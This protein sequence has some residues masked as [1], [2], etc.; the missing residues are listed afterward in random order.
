MTQTSPWRNLRVALFG[1]LFL[2]G[3]VKVSSVCAIWFSIF[4]FDF[5]LPSF[6]CLPGTHPCQKSLWQAKNFALK[7]KS[8]LFIP[9]TFSYF[10]AFFLPQINVLI[11]CVYIFFLA[12]IFFIFAYVNFC[13]WAKS[14]LLAKS[15]YQAETCQS[16]CIILAFVLGWDLIRISCV[17]GQVC[18]LSFDCRLSEVCTRVSLNLTKKS[19]D[20]H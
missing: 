16:F 12:L 6:G 7:N 8:K 15:F 14:E 1:S 11:I 4:C 18:G 19:W 9:A 3:E 2:L 10:S 20:Y 13:Q 5:S 17:F